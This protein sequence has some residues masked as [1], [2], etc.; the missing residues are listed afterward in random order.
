LHGFTIQIAINIG[1]SRGA[2]IPLVSRSAED[3][4]HFS[5]QTLSNVAEVHVKMAV[6]NVAALHRSEYF[7]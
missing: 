1:N 2:I 6:C 3:Q 4:V 7:R 5:L